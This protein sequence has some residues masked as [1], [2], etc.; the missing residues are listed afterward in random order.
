MAKAA[1]QQ[2]EDYWRLTLE[3]TDFN[4]DKFI[5][6]IKISILSTVVRLSHI[7]RKCTRSFSRK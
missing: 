7:T 3:Y 4:G 1:A 5:G 2:Y 6:T